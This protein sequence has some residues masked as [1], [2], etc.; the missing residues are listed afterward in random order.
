MS[1]TFAQSLTDQLNALGKRHGVAT[2]IA[3]QTGRTQITVW[4]MINSVNVKTR[5]DIELLH[6]MEKLGY[7]HFGEKDASV[8]SGNKA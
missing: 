8:E 2:R 3:K 6:M 7:L 4:R 1:S 5:I